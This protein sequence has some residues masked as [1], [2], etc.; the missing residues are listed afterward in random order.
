MY[1]V[2]NADYAMILGSN[3]GWCTAA[4]KGYAQSYTLKG[5]LYITYLNG[6]PFIQGHFEDENWAFL[7]VNDLAPIATDPDVIR[8]METIQ[9]PIMATFKKICDGNFCNMVRD[10]RQDYF[11]TQKEEIL[12]Y[13]ENSE[14]PMVIARVISRMWW[15][16]G[17][18]VLLDSPPYFLSALRNARPEIL[19][20][21]KESDLRE[22]IKDLCA[23]KKELE[24]SFYFGDEDQIAQYVRNVLGGKRGIAFS[25][26]TQALKE[27]IDAEGVRYINSLNDDKDID[28]DEIGCIGMD[29]VF[30]Y[31]KRFLNKIWLD[32]DSTLRA[33]YPEYK[34]RINILKNYKRSIFN[35]EVGEEVEPGPDCPIKFSTGTIIKIE[36]NSVEIKTK[37]GDLHT[38]IQNEA[39][40]I[41]QLAKNGQKKA[42]YSPLVPK[43]EDE[44]ITFKVGMMVVPGPSNNSASH[45][46]DYHGDYGE[47]IEIDEGDRRLT[48]EWE[49][50]HKNDWW[51]PDNGL[52]IPAVLS[53]DERAFCN[54]KKAKDPEQFK[55]GDIVTLSDSKDSNFLAMSP[56]I[57]REMDQD[58]ANVRVAGG[59]TEWFLVEYLVLLEEKEKIWKVVEPYPEELTVG[60][61]VI[62]GPNWTYSN[63]ET[64]GMS[65]TEVAKLTDQDKCNGWVIGT[66]IRAASENKWIRVQ[67]PKYSDGYKY[68]D[69]DWQVI[70]VESGY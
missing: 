4:N 65:V 21:L 42:A 59:A 35:L 46:S 37:K 51:Y 64:M 18:Q 6:K 29:T 9:H 11:E 43:N 32:Y 5:G 2:T 23:E 55:V 12:K 8:M 25:P 39:N 50:G 40:G 49:D 67:W 56:G 28:I 24:L 13:A 10:M 30:A 34:E 38:F 69:N 16:E 70:Q 20:K 52:F 26:S 14:S 44:A 33:N 48:I 53:T 19:K 63:Q 45:S 58:Y 27:D 57:I 22:D 61:K 17:W 54:W 1:Y 60:M 36:G 66:V 31:W 62:R 68:A 3:T 7:A 15:E 41:F 47:V